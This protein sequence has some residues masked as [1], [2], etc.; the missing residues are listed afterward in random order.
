MKKYNLLR[1]LFIFY[2]AGHGGI[3]NENSGM[4]MSDCNL[5]SGN[6]LKEILKNES[7]GQN[8]FLF[9]DFCYSGLL[10][11]IAKELSAEGLKI[12]AI[13]SASSNVSTGSWSYTQTLID[14]FSG[15]EIIDINNTGNITFMDMA[16]EV[17]NIMQNRENQKAVTHRITR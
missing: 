13:T 4:L 12:N 7:N 16:I 8:I 11:D 10:V 17:Q 15:R 9:G 6:E 5:S 14:S 2:F 1:N 3:E